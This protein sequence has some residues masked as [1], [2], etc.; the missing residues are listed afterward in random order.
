M[1]VGKTTLDVDDLSVGIAVKD[2]VANA[3]EIPIKS[4]EE[5]TRGREPLP[6][7]GGDQ[8]QQHRL[9][10][11]QANQPTRR[12]VLDEGVM[13]NDQNLWMTLGEAA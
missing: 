9:L 2:V 7:R 3:L 10:V 5:F 4:V 1:R 11:E 12:H 8:P 6:S 13:S